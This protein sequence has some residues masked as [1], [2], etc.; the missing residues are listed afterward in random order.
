M[1]TQY[2]K[3]QDSMDEDTKRKSL[4]AI[5]IMVEKDYNVSQKLLSLLKKET[6]SIKQKDYDSL[7]TIINKKTTLLD[8]LK[9]HADIRRQWLMSLYKAADENQWG[10]LMESFDKPD[11]VDQ[12]QQVNKNIALCKS[13]NETNGLLIFRGQKTYGKLLYL[14]KG[15][16]QQ[17]DIYTA[18]G[19]K[20]SIRAYA[21]VAKA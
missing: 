2:Q 3:I 5:K 8:Q 19:N 4:E 1:N 12:W 6:M 16:N 13:I 15:G 14:L 7:N 17:S 21:T 11:I 18:K 10:D 20:Q 9:N